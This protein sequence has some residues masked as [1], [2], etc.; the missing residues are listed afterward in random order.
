M[1]PNNHPHISYFDETNDDLKYAKSGQ[2]TEDDTDSG[3]SCFIATA[4]YGSMMEPHVKTLRDFRDKFMLDN[5]A[6]KRFVRLYNTYSPPIADVIAKHDSLRAMVR[7]ILL[8]VVGMSWVAL[9]IGP[10]SAMGF[11]LLLIACFLGFM[12]LRRKYKTQS[13]VNTQH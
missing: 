10:V 3:W 4:A 6:G 13:I 12:G 2:D 1:G 9:K 8:P 11:L 5:A 7:I